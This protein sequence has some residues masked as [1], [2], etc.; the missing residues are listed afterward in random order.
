MNS[1]DTFSLNSSIVLLRL[2]D[3]S[4]KLINTSLW[5]QMTLKKENAAPHGRSSQ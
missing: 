2:G 4:V 1:K 3:K 5:L